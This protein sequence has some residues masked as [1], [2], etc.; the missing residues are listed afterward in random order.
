MGTRAVKKSQITNSQVEWQPVIV[1]DGS[2]D[3]T[4]VAG[5]G[6]FIDVSSATHTINLPANP[7]PGDLVVIVDYRGSA[8]SYN[9]TIGRNGSA[10]KSETN[11]LT[12]SANNETLTLVYADNTAGWVISNQFEGDKFIAA[13]GGTITTSGNYRIHTFTSDCTFSITET[14]NQDHS[15]E[16][17]VVAGG[18]AGGTDI[19]GGGGAGGYRTNYPSPDIGG[20][21]I[22]ATTYPVTV[23]GGGTGRSATTRTCYSPGVNARG[24]S[25]SN[26]VFSTITSA[27]GGGG[28]AY[29]G[30]SPPCSPTTGPVP[31]HPAAN[32]ILGSSGNPGGSGGGEGVDSYSSPG[33]NHPLTVAGSGNTPPV[34]PSQGNDGGAGQSSPWHAAGGGGS[35]GTGGDA[36]AS[37]GSNA[38]SPNPAGGAGDGG[39]GTAN[40]ITG[41]S[42]TY[43]GGGG[44]AAYGNDGTA[45]G[46]PNRG[47]GAGGGGDGGYNHPGLNAGTSGTA[48]TGGG[49]GGAAYSNCTTPNVSAAGSG[50]SGIVVIRYRYQ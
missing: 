26:S 20:F 38:A 25:G 1:G 36:T 9:I 28:G 37:D 34:S 16:Y 32:A 29:N 5:A 17:L 3:T 22:T 23:G 2:T 30:A 40:S 46:S 10:I 45:A 7:N 18:G 11:D 27:G 49:G 8:A 21:S 4:A 6:Y 39:A 41:S 33:L 35:G 42:V 14:G 15:V 31:A 24:P 47:L 43:A 19:G 12:M 44:G 50:G 48:N 13:T